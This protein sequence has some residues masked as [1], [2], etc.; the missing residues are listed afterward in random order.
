MCFIDKTNSA[1]TSMK[2]FRAFSDDVIVRE[3]YKKY[4]NELYRNYERRY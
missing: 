4:A 1:R 3:K 2:S